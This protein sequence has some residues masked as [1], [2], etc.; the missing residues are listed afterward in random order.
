MRVT[1]DRLENCQVRVTVE[2]DAAE[3]EEKLRGTARTL[4]R[5]YN[6]PGYRR[7]K[8]PYHAV[9]RTFGRD[10]VQQQG[11]EDFGQDLYDEA[12]EQV[13]YQVYQAGELQEVEWDPFR[14][15]VL[16][17]IQ[18]ETDL[19]DYRA[20]RV[21]F[22]PE[23]VTEEDVEG[24]LA[25]LQ[26][27]N[28]QWVPVERPAA[29][30]DQVV[31]EF[32]A[33]VG[34]NQILSHEDYE[35]LLDAE[36][37]APLPGFHEQIV[38]M[39][40]GEDRTFVLTV[41]DDAYGEDVAGQEA[42]VKVHLHT[43]KEQDLPGLDDELAMMVGDYDSLDDLKAS[44][45]ENLEIEARQKAESEYLDEVLDAMIEAA[46][47]IEYPPQAVDREADLALNQMERSLET[48]GIQLDAFLGMIGK[49][50]ETYRQELRPSAEERLRKRLVL[51]ELARREGFE[52][53]PE[54][55]EAEIDRLSELVGPQAGEMRQMLDS[56]EGRQSLAD[57]L[58]FARAQERAVQIG[59]GEAPLL[60]EGT[61]EAEAEVLPE[62][63]AEA[64]A[65]EAVSAEAEPPA[66]E[67]TEAAAT[68]EEPI[69]EPAGELPESEVGE[70][71]GP[72]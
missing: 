42:T 63:E 54:E 66:A 1:T 71:T 15:T 45:R 68:A 62:S 41:A 48:S 18:P 16:L 72:D 44:I 9:I 65:E 37:A 31:L 24:R 64:S 11:L 43:V 3:I 46:V 33:H 26:Q 13:E 30:G 21:P 34:D 19:G 28:I 56:P 2:M 27:Q 61:D 40:S 22:E 53:K 57:D 38:G 67:E 12:L 32:Q 70:G 35:L 52:A 55:V 29:W 17:S 58:V 51:N 36:S 20:V 47:K 23:P 25:E 6:I 49:T 60:E 8:A 39:S 4:A 5:R 50:R 59:K 7:G 14:M 69:T 10:A